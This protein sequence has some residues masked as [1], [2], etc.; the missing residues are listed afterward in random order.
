MK[1]LADI[2][3]K[4]IVKA[5]TINPKIEALFILQDPNYLSLIHYDKNEKKTIQDG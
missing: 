5:E 4:A 2:M 1:E 3:R